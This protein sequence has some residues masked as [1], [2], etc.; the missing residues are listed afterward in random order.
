[1]DAILALAAR[2]SG[3]AG[4]PRPVEMQRL[5]GGKNNRVF[6]VSDET[7][8][9]RVLKLY[10]MS[11]SDPR[12]R[13]G[14]EWTLINYARRRGITQVPQPLAMERHSGAAL[15]SFCE[16]EKLTASTVTTAHVE[17]ALEFILALNRTPRDIDGIAPGSEACFS[18]ADHVATVARRV[19]RLA[20][21][22][23]EAPHGAEALDFVAS[24]LMPAWT[25]VETRISEESPDPAPLPLAARIVSPSDFGFHNA[26]VKGETI[27]FIDFE[28]A[29]MDDPAKLVGDFF[30]VPEIPTP[31]ADLHPFIDGLEQGLGLGKA[32]G[33][34]ARLLLD[35]YRIKWAC[36]ILNDFL[37]HGEAR[38]A[39]SLESDRADRCRMQLDKAA[40]TLSELSMF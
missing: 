32:F 11:E 25:G 40:V 36:I 15:Y 10:H 19:A 37:P 26:L 39:F 14:A 30:S 27:T 29:G 7:G 3:E 28:Y 8:E 38:R 24:R 16:G 12:D 34:R 22:D 21:L 18:I 31:I 35:A 23:R 13:L 20:S 2:L 5:S 17:A 9:A 6:R 4:V 1:M 33:V